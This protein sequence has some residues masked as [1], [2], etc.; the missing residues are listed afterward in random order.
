MQRDL[1][2]L[3][4]VGSDLANSDLWPDWA[5]D[6]EFRAARDATSAERN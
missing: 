4:K 2:L 6:S 5:P 3:Y 1:A